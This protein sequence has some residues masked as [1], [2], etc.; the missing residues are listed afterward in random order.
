M[1]KFSEIQLPKEIKP[2]VTKI[3]IGGSEKW[4]T[5]DFVA[6][7]GTELRVLEILGFFESHAITEYSFNG[8]V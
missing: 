3:R 7:N 4:Y 8:R 1:Y 2:K 6:P 5:V